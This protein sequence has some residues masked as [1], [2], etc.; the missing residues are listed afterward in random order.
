MLTS[1]VHGLESAVRGSP[2]AAALATRDTVWTYRELASAVEAAQRA[3]CARSAR[4]GSRVALLLSN[5]P[6]YVAL[7]YGAMAAG[8]VAVP[9]N[10]LE[11]HTTLTQQI[12]HCGASLLCGDPAHPEWAAVSAEAAEFGVDV[13]QVPRQSGPEAV[14][15]FIESLR[16]SSRVEP[17][18]EIRGD[19]PA[20]IFFTSGTTGRPKGVLLSHRNLASN[21]EAI[22]AYLSL[23]AADRGLCVLPMHFSY[24]NSVLN[25]HLI[26][27]A[28][29][30]LED[31]LAF[32]QLILQRM[33]D[34]A[35]TGF[36]GVPSTFSVLR[37]R[38]HPQNFDLR[39]LRYITQA[40][41]AMPSA[42]AS[43]LRQ[44]F[45]AARLFL[46][47][48]Q[49]EATARLTYLPPERL[50]DKPG[51]VGI[52]VSGV[53]IDVIRAG[54]KALEQEIGE[55]RVRGPNVMLGYW[56]DADATAKVL[57]DGWLYTGDL[58]HR[59]AEGYLYLDGRA[60][61]LIKTGSYRVSPEEVEEVIATLAGVSEVG[62]TAVA[63]EL[64]GHAIK[65]VIVAH[66]SLDAKTVQAHCRAR[67]ASYKIP[68]VIEF[69]S[70]LPRTASG[71][72]QR[73]KLA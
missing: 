58:G 13:M 39:A 36:A 71:K 73:A 25:T 32:P 27:G 22:A 68:K 52:P 69:A 17:H 11:R 33:Q 54:R 55:V 38:S 53:E 72:L 21:A 5:S 45:P 19:E 42:L 20:V 43:W 23:T 2:G 31:S 41:A 48:G 34:E 47:Y 65:A 63:D 28:R 18:M 14:T 64:L 1:V 8:R 46:M 51:S 3:L 15:L 7:Y 30:G 61:D 57:R 49:T 24:G 67:L 37:A 9:L 70:A 62:V 10:T 66:G 35:I 4:R 12:R 40:G 6:Q 44:E 26:S 59:D 60:S 16:A 29:L 50:R 56:Q